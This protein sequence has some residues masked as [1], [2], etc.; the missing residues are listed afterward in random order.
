MDEILTLLEEEDV[1]I[2]T[3][4]QI[5]IYIQPPVNAN[6][7]VTDE[8]SGDEDNPTVNN[9]PGNQLLAPAELHHVY[10]E[11]DHELCSTSA[12]NSDSIQ[13]DTVIDTLPSNSE[14]NILPEIDESVENPPKKAK[15]ISKKVGKNNMYLK[16]QKRKQF[17]TI[18][19]IMIYSR[20]KQFGLSSK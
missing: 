6:Q 15:M 12:G 7:D 13:I 9:L 11:P 3:Q 17:L 1:P 16:T 8:D 10:V 18:G 20:I 4:D 5:D 19:A 14:P 2:L